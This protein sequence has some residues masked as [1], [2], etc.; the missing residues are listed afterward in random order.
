MMTLYLDIFKILFRSPIRLLKASQ[1][2]KHINHKNIKEVNNRQKYFFH[3]NYICIIDGS[4]RISGRY[5]GWK[6]YR[7][8]VLRKE[9]A[10]NYTISRIKA[11]K[12]KITFHGYIAGKRDGKTLDLELK[13]HFRFQGAKI[14]ELR[15]IPKYDDEWTAFWA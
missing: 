6:P 4:S 15:N 3:P 12:N 7:D 9:V 1:L 13:Y 14:I 10:T 2:L 5:S 8:K 11:H